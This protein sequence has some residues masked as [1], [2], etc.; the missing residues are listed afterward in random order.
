MQTLRNLHGDSSKVL[1]VDVRELFIVINFHSLICVVVCRR[2]ICREKGKKRS[3]LDQQIVKTIAEHKQQRKAM[4]M[5]WQL[6]STSAHLITIIAL[7]MRAY[8]PKLSRLWKWKLVEIPRKFSAEQSCSNR[9]Q[10]N[11]AVIII[12]KPPRPFFFSIE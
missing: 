6:T 2:K 1:E 8:A 3:G 7:L 12:S 5:R 4:M 11:D 9:M 10:A